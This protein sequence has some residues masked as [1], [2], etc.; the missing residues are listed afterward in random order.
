M[1]C[2]QYLNELNTKLAASLPPIYRW[3]SCTFPLLRMS[4]SSRWPHGCCKGWFRCCLCWDTQ[5][6][7]RMLCLHVSWH[8]KTQTDWMWSSVCASCLNSPLEWA[9]LCP[10]CRTGLEPSKIYP[11]NALKGEI[12]ELKMKCD[13]HEKGCKWRVNWETETITTNSVSMLARVWQQVQSDS[14]PKENETRSIHK[15]SSVQEER[16]LASIVPW[17]WN[18]KNCRKKCSSI[19]LAV[20]TAVARCFQCTGNW[21]QITLAGR[22]HVPTALLIVI[23]RTMYVNFEESEWTLEHI[24]TNC[25]RGPLV[26]HRMKDPR[27]SVKDPADHQSLCQEKK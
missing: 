16:P 11:T 3:W 9:S 17:V 23:S 20:V 4:S 8:W 27:S 25:K 6:K 1:Q 15:E 7:V 24:E 10:N 21:W 22:E 5:C 2:R 14:D 19:Q 12:L 26:W 18:G 13:Q